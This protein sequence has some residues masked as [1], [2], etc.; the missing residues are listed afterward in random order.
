MYVDDLVLITTNKEVQQ[1]EN[2]YI[3]VNMAQEY[4]DQNMLLFNK[5]KTST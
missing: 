2:T 3:A 1:L 5:Q 4:C